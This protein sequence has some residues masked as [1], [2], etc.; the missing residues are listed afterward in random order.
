MK[1]KVTGLKFDNTDYLDL[2]FKLKYLLDNPS[3]IKEFGNNGR[4]FVDN[5]FNQKNVVN[6]FDGYIKN[7]I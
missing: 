4:L 5:N 3:K 1:D 2:V 7:I 6:F